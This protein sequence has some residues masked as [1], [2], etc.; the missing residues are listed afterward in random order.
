MKF[1][2]KLKMKATISKETRK[3]GIVRDKGK[4]DGLKPGEQEVIS[5]DEI[6]GKDANGNQF[7]KL[8]TGYELFIVEG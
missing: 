4:F 3:N 1:V 2:H 8:I 5:R 7:V 6:I